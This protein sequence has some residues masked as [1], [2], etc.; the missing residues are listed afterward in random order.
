ME[1]IHN[2]TQFTLLK[3]LLLEIYQQRSNKYKPISRELE[4]SINRF[5]R[6]SDKSR[7]CPPV[8]NPGD[9]VWLSS[10]KIK[11]TRLTKKLSERWLS[12]FPILEK[13]ISH[14]YNLK[15]PTQ[16]EFIHP[17]FHIYLLEPIKESTSPNCHQAP[18][19]PVIIEKEE[20]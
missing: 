5:E 9:M 2:L 10:K 12:P 20:E 6:Y 18:H 8:Y 3:T 1:K 11:S 14:A 7:A 19:P 13:V 4:F 17:V 15:L 16:W